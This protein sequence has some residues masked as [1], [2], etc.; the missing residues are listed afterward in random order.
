MRDIPVWHPNLMRYIVIG[1]VVVYF[2]S[3]L[4]RNTDAAA[5]DFG[6]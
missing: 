6:L 1:N 3:M 4:S 5:L 2:L